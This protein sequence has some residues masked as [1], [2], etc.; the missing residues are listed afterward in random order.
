[1]RSSSSRLSL[2]CCAIFLVILA[3]LKYIPL[4]SD[5]AS[6]SLNFAYMICVLSSSSLVNEGASFE[7]P[8]LSSKH[9]ING[10]SLLTSTKSDSIFDISWVRLKRGILAVLGATE[11]NTVLKCAG[12]RTLNLSSPRTK[13][14]C[15]HVSRIGGSSGLL[16]VGFIEKRGLLLP[17]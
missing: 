11:P 4:L 14:Y 7:R 9:P 5:S 15:S 13:I 8:L 6:S 10:T 1:M 2:R 3:F 17:S 12:E 16:S